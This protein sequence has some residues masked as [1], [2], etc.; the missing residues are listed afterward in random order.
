[1]VLDGKVLSTQVVNDPRREK[2][3]RKEQRILQQEAER[4]PVLV[5]PQGVNML[6]VEGIVTCYIFT[7]T[8]TKI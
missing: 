7:D 3:V 5:L 6:K 8:I 2:E 4:N 1:V